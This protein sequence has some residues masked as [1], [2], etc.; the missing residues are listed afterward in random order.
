MT[1]N[2]SDS[3]DIPMDEWSN[4]YLTHPDEELKRIYRMERKACPIPHKAKIIRNLITRLEVCHFKLERHIMKII[5]SIGQMNPELDPDTIGHSHPKAGEDAWRKDSTGR[6]RRGQEF[7]RILQMWF[8]GAHY[9]EENSRGIPRSLLWK[10]YD[11]LGAQNDTKST[12]ISALLDRL[13][14]KFEEDRRQIPEEFAELRE[15]IDRTDIC[16]YSFPANVERMIC[17][18]GRLEPVSDFE[19]CGSFDNERRRLAEEYFHAL[20]TWLLAKKSSLD[21]QLGNR[22]PAK[23]WL[24]ACLAKTLKDHIGLEEPMPK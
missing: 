2:L 9:P 23:E 15:Q 13:L 19:G 24:A 21:T 6:S 17:A 1:D 18:I 8:E 10:V 3:S 7:I 20:C 22:T 4:I 5:E 11:D 12:L 16:H 14:W